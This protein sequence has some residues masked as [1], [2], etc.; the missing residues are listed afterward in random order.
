[1]KTDVKK[2][3]STRFSK[4]ILSI[5][6][7]FFFSVV[8]TTLIIEII[9]IKNVEQSEL[10][11]QAE[12]QLKTFEL[13][14]EGLLNSVKRTAASSLSINSLIDTSMSSSYFK[15]A[16]ED[17]TF[18]TDIKQ[19]AVFNYSGELLVASKK[20]DTAWFSRQLVSSTIALGKGQIL[21][22]ENDLY[23]IEPINYYQT[24]QGG[25]IARIDAT[26]LVTKTITKKIKFYQLIL[27]SN[28]KHSTFPE[29]FSNKITATASLPKSTL[30]TEFQPTLTLAKD[31]S[32]LLKEI[33]PWLTNI[34]ILGCVGIF[35]MVF[36]ARKIGQQMA[37]PIILITNRIKKGISPVSP[38]NTSDELEILAKAFDKATSEIERA[39]AEKSK[40]ERKD[41]ESQIR[42]IFNTVPDGII[43]IDSAGIIEAF[44]PAAKLIFGYNTS[45]V[46]GKNVKILMPS[47][48]KKEHDI[49][50]HNY[51]KTG[52]AKIIGIGREISGQRKDG[53]T[54]PME[55]TVAE[56]HVA[57]RQ[58][59]TGIVRDITERKENERLK[60]EF[61]STVS[62][63]LRTPLTSIRGALG[64]ILGKASEYLPEKFFNMLE[65][66]HR[67]SERLTLLIND[68]LDLEKLD[69]E[70]L[71]FEF[72]NVN[73]VNL[74]ERSI[75]DNEAFAK[76]HSVTLYF[77]N[78][79]KEASVIADEHRLQQVLANL[80]SNAIKYSPANEKVKILLDRKDAEWRI[81]VQDS[82]SGVPKEFHNRIFKRFAQADS[83]DTRQKGGTGLGLSIAKAIIERHNGTINYVSKPGR[84]TRFYFDLPAISHNKQQQEKAEVLIC[85]PHTEI[86]KLL[87]QM[88]ELEG[89]NCTIVSTVTDALDKL[90]QQTYQ[91]LLLDTQLADF[92]GL[93]LLENLKKEYKNNKLPI[94][95]ISTTPLKNELTLD[96]DQYRIFDWLEKPIDEK[97]LKK[98][99][100]YTL[101]EIARPHILHI[102]N[103][104]DVIQV[105]CSVLEDF[106]KFSQ[107]TSLAEAKELLAKQHFDLILLDLDLPDGSGEELL[108]KLEK[109][110]PP[111]IVFSAFTPSQSVIDKINVTLTKSRTTNEQLINTVRQILNLENNQ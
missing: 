11:K 97:D 106:V 29:N 87:T 1:M 24:T 15:F 107:A 6:L 85:E 12:N 99:I 53:T 38:T 91:L 34:S 20:E 21:L 64:L 61:V 50:I 73:L 104:T 32:Y 46:V 69:S 89:Y 48:Y 17:L 57:G 101:S 72:T 8:G 80:L 79:N 40:A 105:A 35:A 110:Q 95:I 33:I 13:R 70:Q 25:I 88:I 63:E 102:E 66:A 5:L 37:K 56:M 4:T 19:A 60:G 45:E 93:K 90:K 92:D 100:T 77:I 55:L 7:L 58:L 52:K 103:D 76:K 111:I 96:C 86:A 36:I 75:E 109:N 26:Q 83:S 94:I 78:D 47:P 62:H 51:L 14:V 10:Q 59:F 16:L 3:I 9:R 43:T 81:T 84:G 44:N 22:R 41:S 18:N 2:S 82:G 71:E 42:A 67:N 31:S 65:V 30:L 28:W 39:N 49:H 23:I 108:E 54:F 27:A 74:I 68:I 98:S